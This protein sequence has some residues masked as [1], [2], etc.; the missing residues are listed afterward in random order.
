MAEW[1][2]P[3]NSEMYRV[4]DSLNELKI[5][6][7]KKTS[8]FKDVQE[9]D[10]IYIYAKSLL[11]I[12]YKGAV[13]R[14][15]KL[16]SDIKDSAFLV[17]SESETVGEYIEIAVFRVFDIFGPNA[18]SLRENGLRTYL[19]RPV[20]V[21]PELANYLHWCD[22]VQRKTDSSKSDLPNTCLNPFPINICEEGVNKKIPLSPLA[23]SRDGKKVTCRLCNHEFKRAPRCPRCKQLIAYQIKPDFEIQ[24][25]NS[26]KGI[27]SFLKYVGFKDLSE[28]NLGAGHFCIMEKY[29][30]FSFEWVKETKQIKFSCDSLLSEYIER[31]TKLIHYKN[32]YYMHFSY[33]YL[34]ESYKELQRVVELLRR[35]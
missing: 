34:L 5:I 6:D 29:G 20:K 35:G 24:K 18:F 1:I 11:R 14:V 12:V 2:F 22:D 7:W 10:I 3:I 28:K 27:L 33:S 26:N 31:N 4:V 25:L 16:Q 19:Q 9:G 30:D 8:F 32:P 17:I 13:L 15:N 23:V 21:N